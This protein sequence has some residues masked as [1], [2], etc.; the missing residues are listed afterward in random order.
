MAQRQKMGPLASHRLR[1]DPV[2]AT[3]RRDLAVGRLTVTAVSDGVL[4]MDP[5][6]V[7]S[8]EQPTGAYDELTARYGEARLPIGCF[9][10]RGEQNLLIDTGLGPVDHGGEGT[11]VG[12]NLL[13][14]LA[15]LGLEPEDIDIVA[16]SH[17]HLDHAGTVGDVE[18]G[19][20]T[21]P[22]ATLLLGRDEWAAFVVADKAPA[23]LASY[24][25][26]ALLDLDGRGMVQ[27]VDGDVDVFPGLRRI[28]TPGHTP[29]HSVYV[30]EDSGERLYLVG[31]AMHAPQ[32]LAHPDWVVPFDQDPARATEVRVWLG[33]QA[34]RPGTIGVLGCHFPEFEPATL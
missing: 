25:R 1:D 30:V 27:L 8:P 11:L 16:L 33:T 18:T 14:Q 10:L 23:P 7:G 34:A 26:Q 6:M 21:F 4:V 24:V 5:Q 13:S 28:A 22:N 15:A 17:L 2:S 9:V 20:P 3:A 12:G 29:G 31:D 32:Q 19:Q